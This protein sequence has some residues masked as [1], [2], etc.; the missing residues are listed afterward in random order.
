M[1]AK[2]VFKEWFDRGVEQGATHM[3]VVCDTFDWEDF[4]VYVAPD[5]NVREKADEYNKMSMQKVM[6]VYSLSKDFNEQ[7][8]Q[9]R[10]FSWD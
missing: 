3:I 5:E 2:E 8:S 10:C 4:P 9:T 6:E 1:P 7:H